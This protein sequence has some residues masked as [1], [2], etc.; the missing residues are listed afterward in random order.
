LLEL[1]RHVVPFLASHLIMAISLALGLSVSW[2]ELQA[3][4]RRPVL[5]RGVLVALV[6]LPLWT[7]V[8]V[9]VLPLKPVAAGTLLLM[10]FSPGVI[11][12]VTIVRGQQGNVPLAV[13]LSLT[14]TL[15]AIVLLPV[16]LWVL[17]A[18]FPATFRASP[19]KLFAA[20]IPGLMVP[21][22]VGLALREWAPDFARRLQPVVELFLKA[23]LACVVVM[24][25]IVGVPGLRAVNG[26]SLLAVLLVICGGAFIGHAAGGPRLE[27]RR[28][29]AIAGVL[30]N[31]AIALFV[32]G[33]SFPELK[34]LPAMAAFLVLRALALIPYLLWSKR[35]AARRTE[36]P[37]GPPLYSEPR[38][39]SST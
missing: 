2:R 16:S 1:I 22:G 30:G 21:L 31:P 6:T 9:K 8:V 25:L 17:N 28:T 11:M 14:L 35:L 18:L 15:A 10:A 32:A 39:P 3:E 5:W 33:A 20:I 26:W 19:L 12:L 38:I 37:P 24:L 4:F 27:D 34:L 36:Q 23:V 29:L 7:L 13:A